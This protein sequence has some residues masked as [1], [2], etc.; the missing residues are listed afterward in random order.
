MPVSFRGRVTELRERLA[1]DPKGTTLRGLYST[2]LGAWYAVSSRVDPGSNV[3]ERDWDALVVLDACRVDALEAV[4]DEYEFLDPADIESVVSVGSSGREWLTKTFTTARR[5]AVTET[6][7][8]TASRYAEP[9]FEDNVPGPGVPVP[10]GWPRRKVVDAADFAVLDRARPRG[11]DDRL[12]SVRP[13]YVTECAIDVGRSSDADRFVAHY[14]Q[15]N[16]P[17]V[18]RAAREDR[19][20]TPV[21]AAPLTALRNGDASPEHVWELYLDN[22]RL[23]LDHVTVLLENLDAKTV[24]ITAD[25]GE[26]IGE[27]GVHGHFD[28]LVA[29]AV[30]TVPWVETTAT[31]TGWRTPTIERDRELEG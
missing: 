24:A 3:Y 2:Y 25:H 27:W 15:P 29:P 1:A 30:K 12:R 5:A 14:A 7:Y 23:V 8:V 10:F 4:A 26:A 9:V 18:G 22:L 19:E 20:L 28:G 6:A 17:Y 11:C 21:E 13:S 16:A 31:D